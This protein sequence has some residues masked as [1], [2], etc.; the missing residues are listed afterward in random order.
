M[1]HK[2]KGNN[3]KLGD[4]EIN[5]FDHGFKIERL[6]DR[7]EGERFRKAIIDYAAS[8][9][10]RLDENVALT[11]PDVGVHAW[12]V[13]SLKNAGQKITDPDNFV[14]GLKNYIE[15][16]DINKLPKLSMIQNGQDAT[17]DF[18]IAPNIAKRTTGGQFIG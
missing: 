11:S 4:F 16:L 12:E 5:C 7:V 15:K 6:A 14:K 9:G 8:Q 10:Y 3:P 2:A 17:H 18:S 13:F 1:E